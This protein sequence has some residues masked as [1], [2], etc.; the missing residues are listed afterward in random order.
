MQT[1]NQQVALHT[2]SQTTGLEEVIQDDSCRDAVCCICGSTDLTDRGPC[3]AFQLGYGPEFE[4]SLARN[5][6]P[7][8]LYRCDS[9][10]LSFRAPSLSPQDAVALYAAMPTERWDYGG[11]P[12]AAWSR[13]LKDLAIEKPGTILDVGSF[14]GQFLD[15][16][17]NEWKKFAIEP[18]EEAAGVLSS[19]G[20][21]VI[22]QS[23][24]TPPTE[25]HQQFD[26]VT[27]L[28]VFEHLPNPASG[29]ESCVRYLR[30]GGRLY[31]STGNA[32]H[33]SWKWLQGNHPYLVTPQ[34]I[35]FASPRFFRQWC[36]QNAMRLEALQTHS[37]G[38]KQGRSQFSEASEVAYF[39]LRRSHFPTRGLCRPIHWT[40][41]GRRRMHQGAMSCINSLQDHL[42]ATMVRPLD[43]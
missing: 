10:Y 7:G 37:H 25:P 28:D 40:P 36:Q 24:E 14:D 30:P 8:T 13:V 1:E 12:P 15:R 4:E 19:R 35:R 23:I 39:A 41:A 16:I 9:C 32:E 27:L 22:S 33:W 26:V 6:V 43:R 18:S 31:V 2:S 11:H 5:L 38:E 3:R 42:L 34:H 17:P 29:L 20:I 21:E